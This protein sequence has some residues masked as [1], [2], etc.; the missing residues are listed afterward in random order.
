MSEALHRPGRG[1]GGT[2]G[3]A[4]FFAFP[5]APGALGPPPLRAGA[6]AGPISVRVGLHTG[7]PASCRGRLRRRRRTPRRAGG[8]TGHGGQ[9]VVSAGTASSSSSSSWISAS[10]A[11]R[12][13]SRPVSIFQLGDASFPP[14]RTISNTNLPRP[15]SSFS[16]GAELATVLRESRKG[17]GSSPLQGPVAP[18]RRG[19]RSKL[20]PRSSRSTRLGSSGSGSPPSATP[21]SSRRRSRRRSGP[22]TAS[23]PTSERRDAPLL[24]NLE[25]VIGAAPSCPLLRHVPISPPRH[26]PRAPARPRRGRVPRASARRARGR[27]PLLRASALEPSDEIAELCARLDSLPLAVELAAARTKAL[28]PARSLSASPDASTCCRAVATPPAPAD[29]QGHYR[30]TY[31]LLSTEESSSSPA[32]SVFAGGC[33]LEAA[34]E[35]AGA[36]L[37]TLQS[38][39]EKSLVRFTERYWML[40][41]IREYAWERLAGADDGIESERRHS[42]FFIGLAAR[43]D[44]LR[45]GGGTAWLDVLGREQNNFRAVFARLAQAG[46]IP[47]LLRPLRRRVA[48]LVH[49]R[50]V[51][52][53]NPALSRRARTRSRCPNRRS[54]QDAETCRNLRRQCRRA[55]CGSRL[56]NRRASPFFA[57]FGNH[58]QISAAL[59]NLGGCSTQPR[60]RRCSQAPRGGDRRGTACGSS[61]PSR[62]CARQPRSHRAD[63]RGTSSLPSRCSRTSSTSRA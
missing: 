28:S 44:A 50:Q 58:D 6:P 42:E 39:V 61:K 20:P 40:E 30:W 16:G 38:L 46:R 9:V 41:T 27:C 36:S 22:R 33:T 17:R 2:Q 62:D 3:D 14:L 11:S 4:L 53:K 59:I 63:R 34:E 51:S 13:S 47:E 23:P 32:C 56:H 26:E 21:R 5:T 37:D 1:R 57:E 31:D 18:A 54:R 49:A 29:A 19:S 52:G 24:D 45:V 48:F 43:A 10:T 7:T 35:V 60:A 12:T 55:R 15:A 25:Q 8:R